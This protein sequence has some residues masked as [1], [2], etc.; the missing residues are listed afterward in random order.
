MRFTDLVGW[1]GLALQNLDTGGGDPGAAPS[2][3]D[4]PRVASQIE[5]VPTRPMGAPLRLLVVEDSFM[6]ARL[7]VRMVEDLG[8]KVIGPAPSVNRAMA[9]L[10]EGECDGAIL[11]I[12]LGNESVEPVAKRLADSGLPFIFVSGYSSPDFVDDRFKGRRLLHKPVDPQ[13][14]KQALAD[15]FQSPHG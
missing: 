9:L 8:V 11:D 6:T 7:L 13:A 15:S 1:C 5:S 3:G 10:D 14:F 2:P 12:N 4:P